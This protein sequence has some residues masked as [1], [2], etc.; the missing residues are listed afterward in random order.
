MDTWNVIMALSLGLG[1]SA[2]CGFRVF[3]PLLAMGIGNRAGLIELGESWG[4]MSETLV[5]TA[6]AVATVL[7]ISGYYIPWVDNLLDS[8]TT[9]SAIIAGVVVT[10]A[11]LGQIAGIDPVLQW[12]LAVI[13]GGGVAGTVQLGTAVTRA[14][15]TAVTAGVGNPVVSTVEAGASTT[16]ALLA[17]LMPVLA[18][19]LVVALLFLVV[20][21]FGDRRKVRA[22][23]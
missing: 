2:A 11:S 8:V 7:E 4:W 16:F 15:S 21:R 5:I 18:G 10:S 22:E 17:V 12:I 13:A 6:F 1:L 3:V 14:A 9:P 23:G 19:I 20:R